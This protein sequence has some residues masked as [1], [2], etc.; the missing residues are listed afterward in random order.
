MYNNQGWLTKLWNIHK[1][2]A[3]LLLPN[4]KWVRL[5]SNDLE[6]HTPVFFPAWHMAASSW[7]LPLRRKAGYGSHLGDTNAL[8]TE[9]RS[10]KEHYCNAH[11]WAPLLVFWFLVCRGVWESRGC[12][13][14][15]GLKEVTW[16]A[17]TG[18]LASVNHRIHLHF[19]LERDCLSSSGSSTTSERITGVIIFR[20]T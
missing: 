2:E 15:H 14:N 16:L 8:L 4:N 7:I 12:L 18:H 11:C 17:P 20:F 3:K 10:S 9:L 5:I 13:G 19:V 6:K 1:I